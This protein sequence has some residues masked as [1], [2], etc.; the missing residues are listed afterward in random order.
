MAQVKV[1]Y[2]PQDPIVQRPAH[3]HL[4]PES[5]QDHK[6]LERII[7]EAACMGSGRCPSSGKILHLQVAI[8]ERGA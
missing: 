3:L 2:Y 4:E 8:R 6:T 5:E 7:Q 1:I